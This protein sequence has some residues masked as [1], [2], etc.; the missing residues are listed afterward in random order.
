MKLSDPEL[1]AL[2]Y[3]LKDL[4]S[5][6]PRADIIR[7]LQKVIDDYVPPE[8]CLDIRSADSNDR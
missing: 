4:D 6:A 5:D 3:L 7:G 1:K 2:S 8:V